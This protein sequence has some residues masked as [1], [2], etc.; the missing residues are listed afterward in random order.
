M[1]LRLFPR[2]LQQNRR[3]F[4]KG[5]AQALH[6]AIATTPSPSPRGEKGQAALFGFWRDKEAECLSLT[7]GGYGLGFYQKL[8]GLQVEDSGQ[9]PPRGIDGKFHLEAIFSCPTW[10]LQAGQ[11]SRL[12][13]QGSK[14][15]LSGKLA[16]AHAPQLV[17]D[18]LGLGHLGHFPHIESNFGLAIVGHLQ[19]QGLGASARVGAAPL[20]EGIVDVTFLPGIPEADGVAVVQ[21]ILEL[22]LAAHLQSAQGHGVEGALAADFL[23][24]EVGAEQLLDCRQLGAASH[25]EHLLNLAFAHSP[26]LGAEQHLV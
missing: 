19:D 3:L 20:E 18:H 13:T 22:D 21:A 8:L 15:G 26:C 6:A 14:I 5:S 11:T 1:S 4:N 17:I 2:A 12:S 24:A 23:F 16:A 7:Q 25:Q 10:G 9:Q